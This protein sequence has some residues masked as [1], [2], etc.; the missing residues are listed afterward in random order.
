MR[1][2]AIDLMRFVAAGGIVVFH[3]GA[4]GAELGLAGL[5]FFILLLPIHSLGRDAQQPSVTA[6]KDRVKRFALPWL[7]WSAIYAVLKLLEVVV[8]GAR[9]ETEFKPWMALTGPAIHLWFLPFAL[10][11]TI[12]FQVIRPWL[13][14]ATSAPS[15]SML[16]KLAAVTLCC[17]SLVFLEPGDDPPWAQYLPAIPAVLLGIAL[18]FFDTP[19]GKLLL[20]TVSFL[21]FWW[22]GWPSVAVQLIVAALAYLTCVIFPWHGSYLSRRAANLALTI[23]LVHPMMLSLATRVLGIGQGEMLF[24]AVGLS[25]SIVVAI[26]LPAVVERL[27]GARFLRR[28][29][30]V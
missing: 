1:N 23:Y 14:V 7:G 19:R 4:P 22:L 6:I 28:L 20:V 8:F 27:P 12:S 30:G 25:A 16:L 15:L 10:V 2:G 26:A 17:L 5:Y 24:A 11:V 13:D 21:L 29:L 9:F 18:A 3:A